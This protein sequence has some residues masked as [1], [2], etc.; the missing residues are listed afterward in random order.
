MRKKIILLGIGI[1]LVIMSGCSSKKANLPTPPPTGL[2]GQQATPG[3]T[4]ANPATALPQ[5]TATSQTTT[6]P[7]LVPQLTPAPEIERQF[8]KIADELYSKVQIP[9]MMPLYW[10]PIPANPYDQN[11]FYGIQYSAGQD[12][13]SISITTVSKQLPVNSPELNMPTN[14]S[15]ANQWGNFGG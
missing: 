14:D 7:V 2:Q 5:Q 3:T 8:N 6:N 15:E 13:Y 1:L 12:S 10:P 9:V 4:I 11:N